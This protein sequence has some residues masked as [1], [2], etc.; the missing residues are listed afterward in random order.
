MQRTARILVAVV[1]SL[2]AACDDIDSPAE[3]DH[4][5][6]LAVAATPGCLV[7]GE[8]ASLSVLAADS[9]GTIAP[10]EVRWSL[11]SG[12]GS[13]EGA[14]YR[15][16]ASS[17]DGGGLARVAVEVSLAD[18]APLLGEKA[19]E[20]AT[21]SECPAAPAIVDLT[22]G[23]AA[24]PLTVRVT[25]AEPTEVGVRVE[26]PPASWDEALVTWHATCGEV[27]D[28]RQPT[29]LLSPGEDAC[30][31]VLYAVYRDGRGGTAWIERPLEV[32]P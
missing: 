23:G 13:L 28:Y 8:S 14:S 29:A 5:Q 20:V 11:V 4:P 15:A 32:R 17:G 19:I 24:A 26:P 12:P 30:D 21:D 18:S 1:L 25:G 9:A 16:P 31:G 3:L 2:S 6:L 10:R 22:T 27:D 7:A